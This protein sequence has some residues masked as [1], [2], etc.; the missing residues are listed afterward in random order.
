MPVILL[1]KCAICQKENTK[2][3]IS[4]GICKLNYHITCSNITRNEI[5]VLKK[6]DSNAVFHCDS[7]TVRI[8]GTNSLMNLVAELAKKVHELSEQLTNITQGNTSN[9]TLDPD[10]M[11]EIINESNER[12]KRASNIIIHNLMESAETQN[13][14]KLEINKLISKIPGIQSSGLH[15]IR[16]GKPRTNG[17]PRPLKVILENNADT[18]TILKNYKKL[19]PEQSNIHITSDKTPLQRENMKRLQTELEQRKQN[20]ESDLIIKYINGS[21]KIMNS[22]NEQILPQHQFTTRIVGDSV[23]N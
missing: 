18:L 13:T 2:E 17:S 16:L 20:G 15:S 12:Q 14:D 21:P 7:C 1:N 3:L 5:S 8:D 6:A 22:K 4:C 11:E 10:A 19:L 9:R 23:Q